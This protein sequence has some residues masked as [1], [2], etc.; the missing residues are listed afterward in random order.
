MRTARRRSSMRMANVVLGYRPV[1]ERPQRAATAKWPPSRRHRRRSHPPMSCISPASTL[2]STGTRRARRSCTGTRRCAAIPATPA[3]TS[4]W[5][6]ARCRQGRFERC[7]TSFPRG[8]RPADPPSSESGNRRGPLFPRSRPWCFK[9]GMREA[10]A[11]FYKATWNQAWR[12]A[13][14]Y[15]LACIDCRRGDF[16]TALDHLDESLATN[17]DH[18]KAMVL[19]AV[20]ARHSEDPECAGKSSQDVLALDPLDHWARYEGTFC[21]LVQ[22]RI[23]ACLPQRR[24]DDP[25]PR[26]RLIPTPVSTTMRSHLIERH[27]AQ[28]RCALSP[29][30]SARRARR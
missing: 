30:Q 10:Y 16:D 5:A 26:L 25:R 14:F 9:G 12:S 22:G 28:A 15:H 1:D 23:S 6:G 24:A 13:A 4:A 11:L 29:C 19:Q 2:N 8:D 20:I 18:T 3:A 7:G 27:L 21:G 17:A